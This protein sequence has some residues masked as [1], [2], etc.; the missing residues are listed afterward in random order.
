MPAF[1]RNVTSV[2]T[3]ASLAALVIAGS[4]FGQSTPPNFMMT[5]DASNDAV[6][7]LEYNWEQYDDGDWWEL[8]QG[9]DYHVQTTSARM[10]AANWAKARNKKAEMGS[11]KDHDGFALRF[12]QA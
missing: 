12:V 6:G 9:D 1:W 3:V 8:R 7:A 11:L 10:S 5:W 4:A 2:Q